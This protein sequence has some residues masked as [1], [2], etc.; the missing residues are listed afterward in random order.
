MNVPIEYREVA[1]F[2]GS[3]V[4]GC[5]SIADLIREGLT[6]RNRPERYD[7]D[8]CSRFSPKLPS[9]FC[10]CMLSIYEQF[11]VAME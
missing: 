3:M 10:M 6:R 2:E 8:G 7:R 9:T 5:S 4:R 11:F 1:V